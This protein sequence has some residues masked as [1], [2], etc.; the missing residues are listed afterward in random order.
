[1]AQHWSNDRYRSTEHRVFIETSSS[2]A[3][4]SVPFVCNADFDA[5]VAPADIVTAGAA[6]KYAPIKA[7]QY[8]MQKLGL[9]WDQAEPDVCSTRDAA[10]AAAA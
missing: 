6:V 4:Y 5:Q 2:R 8:I 3:R 9:M 7:G 1:M 10:K